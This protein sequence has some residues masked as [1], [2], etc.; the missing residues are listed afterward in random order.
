MGKKQAGLWGLVF[1]LAFSFFAPFSSPGQEKFPSRPVTLVI[2]YGAG[3]SFDIVSR[4]ISSVANEY[5]GQPL[6]VNMKP[7]GGAV[8]GTAFAARAKP[9]GYTLLFAG[10]SS[11]TI[12]CQ[13]EDT[14]YTKDDF[15]PIAKINHLPYVVAVR[16]DR[17]WKSLKE[18]MDHIRPN[19]KKVIF[20]AT[21]IPGLITLGNEMLLKTA[22]IEASPPVVPFKGVG[23]QVLSILKGDTDYMVQIYLGLVPFIKSKEVRVLAVLD[24]KR[25]PLLPDVPTAK[26]L[27]YDITLNMWETIL[28]PKGTPPQTVEVLGAAFAKIVKDPSFKAMMEKMDIPIMYQDREQFQ[29]FWNDE[30]KQFGDLIQRLDLKKKK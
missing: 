13:I 21:G 4:V 2:P 30:Y 7:G 25:L 16:A 6:I 14:G 20:G 15:I 23:D 12:A 22:K 5:L 24:D 29:N 10:N 27:G 8:I 1:F 11:L 26:E 17:P 9:N 3:G 19:P 28:A 18:L